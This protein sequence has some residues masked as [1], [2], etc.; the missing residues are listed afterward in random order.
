MDPA[1]FIDQAIRRGEANG[2][3]ALQPEEAV[4]FAIAEA[5]VYCDKDGIDALL[6]RYG[7]SK[8]SFFA[9]AFFRV[10]ASEV[11]SALRA[12]AAAPMPV[13]EWLLSEAN[14]LI[15][16]RRGYSYESIVSFVERGT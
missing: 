15:T 12:I 13:S 1:A 10:G 6:S 7:R 9:E 11:A 4:V 14:S 2:F 3:A 8:M 16:Q 5:E